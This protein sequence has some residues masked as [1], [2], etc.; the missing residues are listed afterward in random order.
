MSAYLRAWGGIEWQDYALRLVKRQYGPSNV[1]RVPDKVRGDCGIEF[2]TTCGTLFQCFAPTEVSDV[3]K[4]ASK[5]KSKATTDLA[6]LYRYR[7]QIEELL[8]GIK[9]RRWLLLCPFLDNKAVVSHVRRKGNDI[10]SKGLPFIDESFQALVQS[11]EDFATEIE[12]LRRQL[13]GPPLVVA[14]TA[15]EQIERHAAST[16]S[17]TLLGKLARAY[18]TKTRDE[19]EIL[20]AQHIMGLVRYENTMDALKAEYPT[21]W[22]QAYQTVAGEEDRLVLLGASGDAPREQLERSL[23]RISQGLKHDLPSLPNSVTGNLSRG[24]LSDW[25]MRCPLDFS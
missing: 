6:K 15:P 19:L 10:R 8:S 16:E 5:M 4:A 21:L 14:D 18:P 2:F 11:Q 24:V 20:K 25:L 9:A 12:A 1:Q 22:E 17:R 3:A 7:A 13:V 23:E